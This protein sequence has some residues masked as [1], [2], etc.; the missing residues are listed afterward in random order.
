M[1][2]RLGFEGCITVSSNGLSGG[3]ALFWSR[4]VDV[5]LNNLSNQHIDAMVR[6]VGSDQKE[7]RFTGFYAKAKRS[8]RSESWTLLKWLRCQS[9]VPW[10]CG[11]DFNEITD[12]MEYFGA[13]ERAEWQMQGFRETIDECKFQDMGFNGIPYTWDNR[14]EGVAN[15]KVRLD[16]YL[17]DPGFIQMHGDT[18]VR[19]VPSP[20]S[21]HCMLVIKIKKLVEWEDI[22]P[23]RFVYEEAW[24][25]EESYEPT[26][27]AAWEKGALT[28]EDLNSSLN[29]MQGQLTD[30]KQ[31]K[32]GDIKQKLKKV[33]KEFE[34]EKANSLYRGSSRREKELARQ[35]NGLLLK[36]EIMARA[37]SRADWLKA[38]DQNTGFFHAQAS[39]RKHQNKILV[40]E[41]QDGTIVDSRDEVRA[42]VLANRLREILDEIIAEEQSAFVLGRLIT[43]NAITA[44]EC[45]HAMK[46]KR[47][48]QGWCAVKL[49]MM[50]AY[51]RVEWPYLQGIMLQLGFSEDCRTHNSNI[52]P[53]ARF[54]LDA[55]RRH[56]RWG[57]PV[58]ADLS[59]LRRVPP[60]LVAEVLSAHPPPPPPLALPFFHWAGRQKGFRHCFPAFHALASLLSAAGLPAAADQLPDLIRS[61]GKP[62]SH[63]QLT[64]LVRLHTA[65]RRPLR[66]L[67]TLRRF[68]HEFSVQPQVHVCNRVLG[69]LTA[70]GH[71]EDAL[72][73][74]DEMAESGIR[75]MPVTFA[76]IVRALGQEGMAERILEMIGRMRDEV[77][78]PDVFVYTALVKT[79]VR[80]GHMEACI[81]V[82]E[83][84]GRDGVEPDTVAYATM[85]EGLCN[86]GIVE[87]AAKL[88]EGMRKKGLLVDRIVYASL[89]DAYVAAGRV[90][91]G[92]RILKEMVD[93]GY[94]ADLKTYNILI[95]GLC[96]IGRE[97]KAHNM[98]Q[99]VLQEELVPSSETV[100]QL[101]VCYADKGEMV[102]F[103]GLVDKLVELSLPALEF[104]ADF[105]RLFA[106]KDGRELKTLELFKT[107]RQKGYFSVNIYNI[108][109]ENLLKI[110]ERKKA[111]LLFEEMKASDDCEP[112]SCTYSLMIPCFVDEG[113]IEEA[114]SCYNSMMKAEWIPSLSAYRSLVKGLCKI[115]EINAAVSLVPDCLGNVENGPMEF[116]YT[117]TVIEA[118]RSKDPEKVMKVV[119][120]MIELG[121][122][123]D[124][125]IFSAV[126]YGFCKYATS[127]RAREVFSVMRD[128]DIISEANFIVYEDML[129]EHLK[130]VTADLVISG[131]KF[132]NL[133][134]KLKWR[135]RID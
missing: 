135:S 11:G 133:E 67:Y 127:T 124:E 70:A 27:V 105:L 63:P 18:G 12:N 98:F 54:L 128:R 112:E 17:A 7:W 134:P 55:L 40:L 5:K 29:N 48:K 49:D 117:L 76:I 99:I 65:A 69:A 113:N 52:F 22:G 61:H 131:L 53:L 25:R 58:V 60:I 13:N 68:R 8:E 122:L 64:L 88:F 82:W 10:L 116:K 95:A 33:R 15:V 19:H 6:N 42:E 104:L 72:K 28:L 71:V 93:A 37:R 59:K 102:N 51:D 4:E 103:F 2:A 85:V 16:R 80:R 108:L 36:E 43:D 21:D 66:A 114:C 46:R 75:P 74:F 50:K 84:M 73:L 125:L 91:D 90:G 86:A 34:R 9:D 110:K 23:R 77:C 123:I 129:N 120:E 62:V 3:L 96:G 32:F 56:R 79:M 24:R 101:L 26:V 81:R 14:Q 106:C 89:V 39:R 118:C 130:K 1:K 44:F 121:Y 119:V 31:K 20:Q 38:G 94:C 35:L 126:I 111:L 109:I 41:K 132:F 83:E 100:S 78:R 45:I 92:C 87:K 57:P 47:T 97:D 107:L 115:G 30:W